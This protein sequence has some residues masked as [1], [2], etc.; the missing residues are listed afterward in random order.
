MTHI[1]SMKIYSQ[2]VN[3]IRSKLAELRSNIACSDL[4]IISLIESRIQENQLLNSEICPDGSNYVVHRKDRDLSLN[5]KVGGGGVMVL[6][7]KTLR[8]SRA[9]ELEQSTAIDALW[10]RIKLEN[11]LTLLYGTFYIKPQTS[12]AEYEQFLENVADIANNADRL[13]TVCLVG[14]A[15]IPEI[16]WKNEGRSMLPIE[17]EGRIAELLV[18]VMEIGDLRQINNVLNANNRILDLCLLNAPEDQVSLELAKDPLCRVE[19]HH[20][21]ILIELNLR[22]KRF[23]ETSDY[24][25]YA[26][27]KA[28]YDFVNS[29]LSGVSWVDELSGLDV[30]NGVSRMYTT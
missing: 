19:G 5:N 22:A 17:Y 3:G 6:T 13:T 25:S 8:V 18:H 27:R 10:L 7:R 26:F 24:P 29:E 16:I 30:E 12:Y 15:N 23:T 20:P 28:N 11:G 1:K 21:P 2:N 9:F 14:D 4:D